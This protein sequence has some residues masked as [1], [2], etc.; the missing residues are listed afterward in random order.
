MNR[1]LINCNRMKLFKIASSILFVFILGSCTSQKSEIDLWIFGSYFQNDSIRTGWIGVDNEKIVFLTKEEGTPSKDT[2]F[3]E[4]Q[5]IYPGF[6]D[7]HVHS[8][9]YA[10]SLFEVS[11]F[12]CQSEEEV[13][14]RVLDFSKKHPNIPFIEG[15]GWDQNKFPTQ[16]FPDNH[17]LSEAFP[18]VPVVLKR[19]DGHA[20]W[21]N[22][23]AI[24]KSNVKT[25]TVLSGGFIVKSPE[26]K[27]TGIFIDDAME[28]IAVPGKSFET[29]KTRLL[30]A[31]QN[32]FAA[33]LTSL[34]DA[35]LSL[36]EIK[37]LD[38]LYQSENLTIPMYAMALANEENLKH[39]QEQ[40]PIRK[41]RF[42]LQAFK[43]V[44]DGALGS[45]GACLLHP[46]SDA[47]HHFGLLIESPEEVYRIAKMANQIG[48]QVNTHAIGDSANRVILNEYAKVLKG[49]NNFRWRIEHAQIVQPTDYHFFKEHSII[50]SIQPTHATSDMYWA[51]KR[52]GPER[53]KHAY[54]YKNLL[55]LNGFIA[56]GT[57][58]PI[59]DIYPL[60][61]FY[62]SVARKDAQGFPENGFLKNQG[63]SRLETL[64]GMTIWAAYAQFQDDEKGS[65]DVGK[66]ADFTILDTD[67]LS[68]PEN[69]ILNTKVTS[70]IIRG[71][72][73]YRIQ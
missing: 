39:F 26:G 47:P 66:Y 63:L 17:A 28:L 31:E 7:A 11:L 48:F 8:F 44:S 10:N 19:V 20:L 22:Q 6:M 27:V 40:G 15:R 73:V 56:L 13:I 65:I 67:I 37:T 43:V 61:T 9:G 30:A 45:R 64:K 42:T 57:D 3:F 71:E 53:I 59:E 55:A 34:G 12:G 68:C 54:S 46:Y 24:D 38:S 41:N 33:G 5:F 69:E 35:G 18:D 2:L 32:W 14:N 23:K 50:P 70:T 29:D 21:A 1:V 60:E 4:D 62:A 25:D 58:F 16:S 52:L 36:H 49:Q 51:E 72:E